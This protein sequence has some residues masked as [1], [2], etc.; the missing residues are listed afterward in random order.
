MIIVVE[1]RK[2]KRIKAEKSSFQGSRIPRRVL[3]LWTCL[4]GFLPPLL[5][6][7]SA[8]SSTKPGAA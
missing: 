4:F 8:A 3:H 2:K 7:R 6:N 5:V 1:R